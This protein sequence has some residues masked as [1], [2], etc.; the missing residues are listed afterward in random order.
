MAGWVF[1]IALLIYR[2]SAINATTSIILPDGLFW[3]YPAP[4]SFVGQS[5]V[6]GSITAYTINCGMDDTPFWPGPNGCDSNNSYTFSAAHAT[7]RFLI[8]L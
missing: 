1:C 5:T 6:I 2:V 7:T 8:P 3:G 4:Q